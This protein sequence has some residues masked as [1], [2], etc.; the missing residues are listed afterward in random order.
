MFMLFEYLLQSISC[1]IMNLFVSS[2][3]KDLV[4]AIFKS[5]RSDEIYESVKS[6]VGQIGV[7]I[8]RDIAPE[9]K[10][11]AAIQA[12]TLLRFGDAS[13]L[14]LEVVGES[15]RFSV[16]QRKTGY[17]VTCQLPWTF[18]RKNLQSFPP[19][20][21]YFPYTYRRYQYAI[22]QAIGFRSWRKAGEIKDRSHI[23]RH[24]AASKMAAEGVHASVISNALG[25][26]SRDTLQFYVDESIFHQFV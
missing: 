19:N 20:F 10:P 16:K 11:L 14:D 25:Q 7:D 17:Y 4:Q 3:H 5:D 13:T 6:S 1:A 24:L 21:R 8:I 22:R 12:I 18:T 23:F 9:F 26:V 2:K 15:G